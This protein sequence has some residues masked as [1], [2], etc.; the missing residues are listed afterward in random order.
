MRPQREPMSCAGQRAIQPAPLRLTCSRWRRNFSTATLMSPQPSGR[1]EGVQGP[2][3]VGTA[4]RWTST[5][6]TDAFRSLR[7]LIASGRIELPNDPVLI[8]EAGRLRTKPGR[9]EIVLPRSGDSHCDLMVALAGAVL[10]H[11][12]HGPT[13]PVRWSRPAM[14]RGGTPARPGF[15]RMPVAPPRGIARVGGRAFS[16]SA[17]DAA[18]GLPTYT[19]AEIDGLQRRL[20]G[21]R[22]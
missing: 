7:A 13:Q 18:T 2:A 19:S 6:R 20:R 10:E 21:G 3:P 5:T 4:R 17:I 9:S 12:C 22:R 11:E 1:R 8:A 14:Q 16:S 15:A